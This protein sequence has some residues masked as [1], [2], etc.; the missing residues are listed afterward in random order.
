SHVMGCP[1]R[2]EG[3]PYCGPPPWL[4][5]DAADVP[6]PIDASG[7]FGFGGGGGD[8]PS[9]ACCGDQ[10]VSEGVAASDCGRVVSLLDLDGRVLVGEPVVLVDAGGRNLGR[11]DDDPEPACTVVQC[12]KVRDLFQRVC[13]VVGSGVLV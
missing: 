11:V 13:D 1:F 10:L 5:A 12:G 8:V 7:V 6:V 9:E 4:L 3:G 2:S